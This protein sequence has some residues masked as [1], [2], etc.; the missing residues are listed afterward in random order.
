MVL[1]ESLEWLEHITNSGGTT[2]WRWQT[3]VAAALAVMAAVDGAHVQ[4]PEQ[5]LHKGSQV[6]CALLSSEAYQA[7]VQGARITPSLLQARVQVQVRFAM[8]RVNAASIGAT[9]A[10][11]KEK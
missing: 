8:P 1:E 7:R 4:L 3:R 2:A 10:V 11:R 9:I 6:V 5:L